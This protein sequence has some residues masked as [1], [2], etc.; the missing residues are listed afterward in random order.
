MFQSAVEATKLFQPEG[1]QASKKERKEIIREYKLHR[2]QHRK[3]SKIN[4]WLVEVCI[5]KF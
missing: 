3:M 4:N 2:V 1:L 5:P